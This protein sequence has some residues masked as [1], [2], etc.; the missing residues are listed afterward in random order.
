M[1][2][3]VANFFNVIGSDIT[4]PTSFEELVPYLVTVYIGI[5]LVGGVFRIIRGIFDSMFSMRRL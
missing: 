5:F 2:Q 1:A 3:I 4:P